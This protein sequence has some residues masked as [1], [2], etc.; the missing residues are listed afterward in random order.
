MKIFFGVC[1]LIIPIIMIIIGVISMRDIPKDINSFAGYRTDRSM[2]NIDTWRFANRYCGQLW[3]KLGIYTLIISV[4]C[5]VISFLLTIEVQSIVS[6][7]LTVIQIIIII[8]SVYLVE[9]QLKNKFDENGHYKEGK[10]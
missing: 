2:K 4:I 3:K 7:V 1:N 10:K 8:F 5:T 9:K 6:L